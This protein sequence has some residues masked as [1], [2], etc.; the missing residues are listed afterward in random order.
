V[1]EQ[2]LR[3]LMLAAGLPPQG[4]PD[5]DA[6]RLV[7]RDDGGDPERAVQ[8]VNELVSAHR[9][10]AIVGPIDTRAA[11]A[12]AERAQELG[13]PL[14]ALTPATDLTRTG[15]MIFRLFTAPE[16]EV[17]SLVKYAIGEGARRFAVLHPDAPFGTVMRDTFKREV[18]RQGGEVVAGESYPP[19]STSFG[20]QVS[21]LAASRLQAL[22]IADSASRIA[23]IAPALAAAGLWSTP[24]GGAAPGKGRPITVLAPSVGFAPDL[25]G[26]AG[27]YL[28][29]AV[30]SAPFD[31]TAVGGPPQEFADRFQKQFGSSPDMFA[32]FAHDAYRLVREAVEKGARTREEV[33]QSLQTIRYPVPAGPSQGF[34]ATREPL[35]AVRLLT[36]EGDHFVEAGS[37]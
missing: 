27:R 24:P 2:A 3:G 21:R 32:A 4:P 6:A 26:S 25:A 36:L 16:Y 20:P 11:T 31:P 7:F 29:G 22:F 13:V 15:S 18:E 19:A 10:V 37:N 1:G 28:Q 33:A 17:Q 8:A 9:V 35:Q 5:P 12:A 34:N 30:F 23:L 14:I